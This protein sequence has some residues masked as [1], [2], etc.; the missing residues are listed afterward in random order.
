MSD[1]KDSAE[2]YEISKNDEEILTDVDEKHEEIDQIK[3]TR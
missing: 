1:D 2:I 3:Q